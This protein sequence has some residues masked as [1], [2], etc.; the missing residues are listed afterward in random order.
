MKTRSICLSVFT[1]VFLSL[2]VLTS[3]LISALPEEDTINDALKDLDPT[4]MSIYYAMGEYYPPDDVDTLNVNWFGGRV[5][6]I[7]YNESYYFVEESATRQLMENERLA[8][9]LQDNECTVYYQSDESSLDDLY[10]KVEIRIP[11]SKADKL[12]SLN[13]NTNGEVIIKNIVAENITVNGKTGRVLCEN[14]YSN[15]TQ[16]TTSSGNV[17][18]LVNNDIGYSMDFSSKNGKM[19][20]YVDNGLNSYISG[21]GRYKFAV[22]TKNGDL[23]IALNLNKK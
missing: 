13:I 6:I 5:E 20:S 10:K 17:D 16:L 15:S 7:A 23:K 19:T 12:K 1:V 8:F 18:I 2:V 9:A 22:K 4:D 11:K 14:T 21:D 3:G